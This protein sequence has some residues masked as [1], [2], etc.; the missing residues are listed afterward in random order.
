MFA[1]RSSNQAGK[2][3]TESYGWPQCL[4][5]DM[6]EMKCMTANRAGFEWSTNCT[7]QSQVHLSGCT[8]VLPPFRGP[9]IGTRLKGHKSLK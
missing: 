6:G 8:L 4:D 2:V 9:N 7:D 1:Y 5:H 3:P